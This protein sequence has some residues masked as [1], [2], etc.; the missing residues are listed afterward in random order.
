MPRARSP[1]WFALFLLAGD[2]SARVASAD[3]EAIFAMLPGEVV[4]RLRGEGIA[5]LPGAADGKHVEAVVLFEQPRHRTMRLLSQTTRQHEFRPELI[6]VEPILWSESDVL[7]RHTLRVMFVPIEYH[8]R[9]HFD[10]ESYRIW[11][12]LDPDS[13]N[14]LRRL[15][16]FWQLEE[17]DSNR[18]LGRFGSRVEV[19]PALPSFLQD[20]MTR[21]GV[22]RTMRQVRLWVN[23]DGTYRP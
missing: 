8:L 10:F 22:T 1:G 6:H 9:S 11:W 17:L 5:I 23:S 4:D 21:R 3:D 2:L 16:G 13:P 18:T 7:D 15:E 20:L 14:D 19:G 12:E